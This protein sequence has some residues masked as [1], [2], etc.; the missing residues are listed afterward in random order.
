[1]AAMGTLEIELKITPD[2]KKFIIDIM[3]EETSK[4]LIRDINSDKPIR[5]IIQGLR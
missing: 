2:L 4:I 3:K 1:M 5:N